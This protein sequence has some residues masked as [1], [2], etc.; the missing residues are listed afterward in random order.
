MAIEPV[1]AMG[2]VQH[3]DKCDTVQPFTVYRT[4]VECKVCLSFKKLVD[5]KEV[6]YYEG[7]SL[8]LI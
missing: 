1:S 7:L 6:V 2:L 3:C 8:L 4:K 5:R